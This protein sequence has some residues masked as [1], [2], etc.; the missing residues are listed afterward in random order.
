MSACLTVATELAHLSTIQKAL[1]GLIESGVPLQISG[2]RLAP[3]SVRK[4]LP[5]TQPTK[6]IQSSPN[7]TAS[8]GKRSY[9][10]TTE[11]SQ[12]EEDAKQFL[13]PRS[14]KRKT[15]HPDDDSDEATSD[16]ESDPDLDLDSDDDD[17]EV[18]EDADELRP[19]GLSV[20]SAAAPSAPMDAAS[21]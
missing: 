10:P 1:T 11:T 2:L 4:H 21:H 8:V 9:L 18:L 3:K 5:L 6:H 17:M 13:P 7:A 16:D 14:L 15:C 20:P 19:L 12:S